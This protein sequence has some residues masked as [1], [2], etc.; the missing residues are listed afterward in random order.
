LGLQKDRAQRQRP[1]GERHLHSVVC[2]EERRS[3]SGRTT[4]GHSLVCPVS[5]VPEPCKAQNVRSPR[6]VLACRLLTINS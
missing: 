2:Y 3:L 4:G 6:T 1:P 5:R